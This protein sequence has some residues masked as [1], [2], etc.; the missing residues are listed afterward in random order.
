MLSVGIPLFTQ[1]LSALM[2][3]PPWLV[4]SPRQ[5]GRL[6]EFL[7]N[8]TLPSHI[9][10]FTPPGCRLRAEMIRPEVEDSPSGRTAGSR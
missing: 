2:I 8:L 3:S 7:M 10:A 1:R 4:H 9:P 6:I 5:I